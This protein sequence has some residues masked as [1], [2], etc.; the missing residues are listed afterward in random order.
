MHIALIASNAYPIS[1]QTRKG[2]ELFVK[3]YV[4]A[5][6]A[7]VTD[8][9]FSCTVFAS[10]DSDVP[11]PLESIDTC[12]T[13]ADATI[14]KDK[15]ILFE[16]ALISKAVT[17]QDSF[18]LFHIH[19]GNGDIL[20]P[21]AQCIHKP[22]LITPH[23]TADFLYMPKYFNLFKKLTHVSF[24]SLSNNQRTMLPDIQWIQTIPH[25]INPDEF[26]FSETGG[27]H[28]FW[29][30]RALPEKGLEDAIH[31]ATKT[32][33]ELT[34]CAIVK[35]DSEPWFSQTILPLL[36][37]TPT[38]TLET[39][40]TRDELVSYYQKSKAFLFPIH[41]EEPF[42]L[43]LIEALACGTPVVAYGRGAVPEII[44]DGV[45]G[46]IVNESEEKK[47]GDYI[48]KKFGIEGLVE[49]VKR[50]YALSE[51]EYKTMRKACHNDAVSRYSMER[52]IHDYTNLYHQ[53]TTHP[54]PS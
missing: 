45:T 18:D 14:P 30:A 1:R 10:G 42:G 15:P 38:I 21:F 17:L 9:N 27:N 7:Y 47:T 50:I 46:F 13:N 29:A 5:L 35:A 49:A 37:N 22:I 40:K 19:I 54:I 32:K 23:Y 4:D 48:I 52:M 16:L 26:P 51:S 24:V 12:A 20:L 34:L 6:H 39:Q 36:Q 25:G 11:F 3:N 28:L 2:T 33:K 8:E 53:L 43:V 31:V 41:W 44:K